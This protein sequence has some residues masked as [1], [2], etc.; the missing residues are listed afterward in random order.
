MLLITPSIMHSGTHLLRHTILKEFKQWP[1]DE[2][3][4]GDYQSGVNSEWVMEIYRGT[5]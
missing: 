3:L 1:F 4:D 5:C 2:R